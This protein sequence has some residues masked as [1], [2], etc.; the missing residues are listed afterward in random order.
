M[1]AR[2]YAA[3]NAVTAAFARHGIAKDRFNL[4]DDY[5]YR[6]IDDVMIRLAPLL[7]EHRLCVLPR[8]LKREVTERCGLAG[9]L[10]VS[11]TLKVAYDLVSLED[12]SRHRIKVFGEALDASDKA[13]SK[14][15]QQAWKFAMIQAFA[16]PVSG[17]EDVDARSPRLAQHGPAP[18]E[19]WQQ[20]SVDTTE[21]IR[22]CQSG[23]GL[24]Q[25]QQDHRAT[26]GALQREQAELYANLGRVI[27]TR[28]AEIA[29]AA[30]TIAG[31]VRPRAG[32]EPPIEA[33]RSRG[34][35]G[36]E[37][38]PVANR[39]RKRTRGRAFEDTL[40]DA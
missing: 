22:S 36:G 2:V 29:G 16:I 27:A 1:I 8:V 34:K 6:S 17:S 40:A 12:G 20:W 10:L 23:E 25:L 30:S 7:A 33:S 39:T 5:A 9:E 38:E 31:R 18:A 3:I 37:G 28:R 14:A 24:D 26:L 11:V 13:T 35:H 15:M 21:M 32:G 4:A 19:G